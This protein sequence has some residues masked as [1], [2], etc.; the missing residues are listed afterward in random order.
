MI[1]K[2]LGGLFIT[3]G[4]TKDYNAVGVYMDKNTNCFLAEYSGYAG[5]R[6]E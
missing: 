5:G 6:K 3:I 2:H 1:G 4:F